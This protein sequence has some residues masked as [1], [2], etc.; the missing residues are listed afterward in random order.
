MFK[1]LDKI[2]FFYKLKLSYQHDSKNIE[3]LT[4]WSLLFIIILDIFVY[5]AIEMGIRFQ[6]ATLNNPETKITY[7]CRNSV[8]NP[9]LIQDYNWYEYR[10]T[11]KKNYV[12]DNTIYTNGT[13][14]GS[15]KVLRD[16]RHKELDTRCLELQNRI[17]SIANS[18]ELNTVKS[19]IETLQKNLSKYTTDLR[20]IQNNYNTVLF[21]K[22]AQ[23]SE[24]KSILEMDLES[25][26]IKVKYDDLQQKIAS[27]QKTIDDLKLQFSSNTLVTS[28][29]ELATQQKET[30]LKD[31][32]KATSRY[33]LKR[34]GI[35]ILFLL[36]IVG[37]FYWQMNSQNIKR[38]YTKYI[39]FKNIFVIGMVF[40]VL[41]TIKIVYNYIPHVFIQNVLMFFYS[42][43]IPFIAYYI[44]LALGIVLFSF[45]I[46][47]L[48]SATKN[49]KR[50]TI[51][52]IDSYKLNKCDACGVKVDYVQMNFCPNCRNILK[53]KCEKCGHYTIAKL[54]FCSFC[55]EKVGIQKEI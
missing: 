14:A 33:F 25:K 52:F 47:K 27:T 31:Y 35:I 26:N 30:I 39:I 32:E 16:I 34:A 53:I 13:T 5:S 24:S 6:T 1:L 55:S 4:R 21:E 36:P 54:D 49:K 11:S 19:S 9:A 15:Q 29:F 18:K 51:T 41:N 48:Q 43:Q 40:L 20:Y 2:K 8:K 10:S 37:I 45:I 50:T 7:Q 17:E 22:I 38:N 12:N 44:L 3:K 46:L 23:Q 28:L 42:I